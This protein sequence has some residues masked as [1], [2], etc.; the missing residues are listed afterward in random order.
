MQKKTNLHKKK[1]AYVNFYTLPHIKDDQYKLK[2]FAFAFDF[3]FLLQNTFSV[4]VFDFIGINSSF[5]KKGIQFNYLKRTHNR[6]LFIPWKL[7]FRLKKLKPDVVYVQGLN[8]PHLILLMQFFLPFS[9]KIYVHDHANVFPK[10]IKI[11]LFKWADKKVHSYFFTAKEMAQGYLENNLISSSEKIIACVEGSTNFSYNPEVKK[12][13]NKFIWVGRLD[14]NKDP[15]TVLNA[16]K[17]YVA[18]NQKAYLN[19]F[20]QNEQ[21]LSEIRDFISKNNLKNNVFLKGS[22]AHHELEKWYQGSSYFLLGSLKEGGPIS[23]IEAMACGCIPIVTNIPAFKAM[24]NRAAC[25]YLFTPNNHR[26]LYK[27]LN[28]L[29]ETDVTQKRAQ[30]LS[31]FN[32]S[33]SHQ[34]IAQTLTQ[35]FLK[36]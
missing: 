15:L 28:R 26:E 13:P 30:V 6:K 11:L 29:K 32:Q 3:L 24:T 7:F 27:I 16:F 18:K 34:A 23:L 10:G 2:K 12:D 35:G 1:L 8:Y 20:Y 21:L 14:T 19:M 22:V 17:K 25:G 36:N 31:F 9:C 4:Y 33:L 5:K